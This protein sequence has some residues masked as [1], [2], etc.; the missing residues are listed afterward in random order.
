MSYQCPDGVSLGE[1]LGLQ[2]EHHSGLST[3]QNDNGTWEISAWPANLGPEPTQQQI[4]TWAASIEAAR[5][6]AKRTQAK[7]LL[8]ENDPNR[9]LLRA[10]V[11]VLMAS[12][13]EARTT[14]NSLIAATG[15]QVP[16]LSNKNW[17][18]AVAAAQAV[19]D[20][21]QAEE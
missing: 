17:S 4:T 2:F 3:R 15:A 14:I 6:T 18:Q 11:K 8:A 13:V 1:I 21:G 9:V 20:A 10:I 12:L 5:A 7:E 19:I 16:V